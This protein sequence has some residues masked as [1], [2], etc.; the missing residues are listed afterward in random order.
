MKI[1]NAYRV[2]LSVEVEVIIESDMPIDEAHVDE[3]CDK[4]EKICR[5]HIMEDAPNI[6]A[7]GASVNGY[8]YEIK[9]IDS[10]ISRCQIRELDITNVSNRNFQ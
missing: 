4:Q 5:E 10:K 6:N 2:T 9:T 1:K 8:T 3:T 7:F